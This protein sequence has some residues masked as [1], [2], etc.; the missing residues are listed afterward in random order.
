MS[1]DVWHHGQNNT[2]S[3]LGWVSLGVCPF[4]LEVSLSLK[5][6]ERMGEVSPRVT[7]DLLNSILPYP[8]GQT[9]SWA[10][11]SC[12]LA[13]YFSLHN[14]R[15]TFWR[16]VWEICKNRLQICLLWRTRN[17][18]NIQEQ[19]DWIVLSI[20]TGC[21]SDS[22]KWRYRIVIWKKAVILKS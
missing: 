12:F 10:F 14:I 21:N 7:R 13:G 9:E 22:W 1:L 2:L 16:F 6:R 17:Y 15:E 3:V 4:G 5:W 20:F 8:R 18:L 19:I 11:Y